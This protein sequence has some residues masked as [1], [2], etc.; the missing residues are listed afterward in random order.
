M[1]VVAVQSAIGFTAICTVGIYLRSP[2]YRM[3]ALQI[4]FGVIFPQNTKT[5]T[6]SRRKTGHCPRPDFVRML[7]NSKKILLFTQGEFVSTLG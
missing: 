7:D 1:V 5:R 2:Q 6:A 3:Q 4:Y